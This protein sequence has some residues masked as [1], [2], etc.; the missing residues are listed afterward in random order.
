VT[1]RISAGP[2]LPDYELIEFDK[3]MEK[4]LSRKEKHISDR[5]SSGEVDFC[6]TKIPSRKDAQVDGYKYEDY[7]KL[8]FEMCDQPWKHIDV[9]HR[10]LIAKLNNATKVRITNSDGTDIEMELID[11]NGK[12]YTFCNS[13]IARNIP[14]SEVFSAPRMDSVNGKIVAKGQFNFVAGK[15]IRDLTLHIRKGRIESFEAEEGG[16]YFQEFLD[17]S[18]NNRFFGELGIGTNPHLKR[19]VLNGL[20]VEKIGGS[21]HMACGHC[22]TMTQYGGEPVYVNNGNNDTPDHWDI[23]TMLYG[24]EGTIELDGEPIMEKGRF[25]DPG[26]AVLNDGW[27]AV[28]MNERPD[29]WK[30]FRGY[31]ATSGAP[32]WTETPSP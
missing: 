17:R 9:A 3:E 18:E 11:K 1:K 21:F 6:L 27:A 15:V 14:G 7:V 8:F 32:V 2:I 10:K 5:I 22:Y 16:H 24:K 30:N 31:D 19:H 20:L 28:P 23:T 12:H 26:L 25:L 13:L 29:R 4:L